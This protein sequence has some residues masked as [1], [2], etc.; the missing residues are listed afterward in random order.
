MEHLENV[1]KESYKKTIEMLKESEQV[2][3][4]IREQVQ[5][6]IKDSVLRIKSIFL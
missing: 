6:K 1:I 2:K 3:K 5:V 4:K